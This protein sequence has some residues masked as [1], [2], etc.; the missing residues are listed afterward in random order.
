[1]SQISNKS[2]QIAALLILFGAL[3]RL[4][5]HP[6][7][8]TALTALGLFS[9][10]Y[11]KNSKLSVLILIGALLFSDL[12]IGFHVL[13]P[14]VYGAL[15]IPFMF[16]SYISVFKNKAVYTL[17]SIL[18]SSVSFFIITNLAVWMFTQ[19]YPKT[20]EGLIA[21]FVAAIPFFKNQLCG[22]VFYT[23]TIFGLFY[24]LNTTVKSKTLSVKA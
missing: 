9:G 17:F 3:S 18:A 10:Y 15:L 6:A 19:L 20:Y 12:L 21:C 7:N 23:I 13:M 16:G 1:M 22:D 4:I 2:F 14:V 11:F 24:I 8:F 5:P